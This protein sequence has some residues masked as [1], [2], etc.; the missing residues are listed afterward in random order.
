MKLEFM[1][2]CAV[3]VPDPPRSRKL[4]VDALGLPL[5]SAGDDEYAHSERIE[6]VKHFGVWPLYQAAQACFG[7]PDWPAD[8]TVPQ[9]SV[10]FDVAAPEQ[11]QAAADELAAAGHTLLHDAREEPW[12]QTVARVQ[13]PEG[14]IVGISFTPSMHDG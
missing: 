4:Y 12:G 5:E 13:A 8:R 9:A 2:S 7:T 11:V 6:G 1:A 3:I 14:T 10:E